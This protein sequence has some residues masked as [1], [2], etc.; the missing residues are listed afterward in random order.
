LRLSRETLLGGVF[1]VLSMEFL[2]G[3]VI[4]Q[5]A[6]KG[7]QYSVI[8]DAI[9]DLGVTVCGTVSI[10]GVPGY[11][12]SP[13]H[14]VM[15][16]SFVLTGAFIVLGAYFT[17]AAWPWSRSM[18]SGFDALRPKWEKAFRG[19]AHALEGI[20]IL[21]RDRRGEPAG[22]RKSPRTVPEGLADPCPLK[23]W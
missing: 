18:R 3:Q 9:S 23:G 7:S 14:D 10:G 21:I 20:D 5:S 11:Y 2:V 13:L 1:R 12:C 19:G 6:W 4:A 22:L 17:R 8:N 15:N 16:A